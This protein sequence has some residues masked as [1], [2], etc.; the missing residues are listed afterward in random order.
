MSGASQAT[1]SGNSLS[2]RC[3]YTFLKID[4]IEL[5]CLDEF[6]VND[7]NQNAYSWSV[8]GTSGYVV[9]NID[10]F[11]TSF[12]ISYSKSVIYGLMGCKLATT[13]HFF[14]QFLKNL[15]HVLENMFKK[16]WS[17]Y[18]VVLDKV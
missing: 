14:M 17:Q 1:T 4:G 11:S 6:W 5:I 10:A 8:K 3:F 15:K 7:R 13:Q 16:S 18:C 12:W 9:S 2:E